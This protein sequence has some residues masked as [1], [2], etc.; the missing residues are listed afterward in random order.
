MIPALKE[1]R[2]APGAPAGASVLAIAEMNLEEYPAF[3]LGRR[4]RRTEL[5]YTRTRT[6]GEGRILEQ[7]WVVRGVEGLGLPGPFEQDLYV[8]LL[9]LFTE[10]GLPPDGRIRFTRNRLA[11]VMGC[12]NSGRGYELLEQGL[13]RLAGATVHTEH[14]FYRPGAIGPKGE[15]NGPAERL[16]L[17]FHILEEVRVYERRS[18]VEV[19]P[20]GAEGDGGAP[21]GARVER[22]GPWSYPSPAWASPWCRATSGAIQKDS[23][24]P[25]SSPWSAPWPSASTATWTRCA[26]GGGASRSGCWPWRTSWAWSTAIPPTSRMAWPRPTLS[27]RPRAT[28]PGPATPRWPGGPGRGR[29]WSTP[30]SRPSTAGPGAGPGAS[31]RPSTPS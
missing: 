30:S 20:Q 29:R 2:L 5:R 23:T 7:V 3:R 31:R 26:T 18:F 14:A 28:W 17:D 16:S 27:C 1:R 13:S 10:Q 9:V 15:R 25:S 21:V 6:D 4:S 8:A 22:G 12:S 11:Q 19:A 24:P